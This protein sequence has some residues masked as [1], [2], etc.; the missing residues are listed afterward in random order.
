MVISTTVI[1]KQLK[2]NM[3]NSKN[4]K[5]GDKVLITKYAGIEGT[6]IIAKELEEYL[7]DKIDKEKIK[8]AQDMGALVSVVKEGIICGKIGVK[9]MHDITEGGVLGA[10]WEGA[11]AT[12]KGIKIYKELIPMKQVT[13]EIASILNIDPYRLISSGSMLI[14]AEEDKIKTI[15]SQLGKEGIEINVIGEIIE[16]GIL[17]EENGVIKEIE[18]PSSDEL[19]KALQY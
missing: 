19:Y 2:K 7:G 8:E 14:I 11:I 12:N 9:Y 3:L 5:V 4:T 13:K 16:E 1:G 17:I 15:E 10:I 18:A 6:S